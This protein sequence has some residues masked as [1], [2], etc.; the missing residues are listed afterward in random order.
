MRC[1]DNPRQ[2]AEVT[3]ARRAC[4]LTNCCCNL[5]QHLAIQRPL[6]HQPLQPGLLPLERLQ[7][8]RLPLSHPVVLRRHR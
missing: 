5:L 4:A 8:Q 6:G 1:T 2:T 7:T 3:C